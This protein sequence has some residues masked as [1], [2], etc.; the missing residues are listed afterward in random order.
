MKNNIKMSSPLIT[1][2]D[3]KAVQEVLETRYLSNG[4]KTQAFEKEL[5]SYVGSKHG[6]CVNSGTSALHLAVITAGIKD[7]DYVI[8]TPFSF[9]AS[10]NCMLFERAIPVFVDIDPITFNIDPERVD[11]AARDLIHGGKHA[12]KWLPRRM[13]GMKTKGGKLK[14]ILPVDIFGQPADYDPLR[15]TCDQ[16]DLKMIEDSCEAFGAEYKKQKAGTLGDVGVF[17]FYPNKQMTTGEG[18]ILVTDNDIWANM[19]RSLRNQGRDV[20]DG[21]LNHS[22]LGYNYRLDE[23][24]AALG[25]SQLNRI[26]DLLDKR[27]QVAAWYTNR[28]EKID[29][30]Q[31]PVIV[32]TTTKMSWFVYVVRITSD[33]G[34]DRVIEELKSM[35]IPSRQYFTPI[36]LQPFYQDRFG[37]QRDD[38]PETESAGDQCLALP[39][40]SVM[41]EDQVDIVCEAIKSILG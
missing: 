22:R 7:G 24:S 14:A 38:Y 10:A 25:L 31:T 15:K 36:H 21:W 16:Y 9:V 2:E 11:Q 3:K 20:F 4:P 23:M 13:T 6:V 35:G 37:Y 32:P 26:E 12:E 40:S 28:L 39:F 34:R 17:A 27:S 41:P 19:Y 33:I 5:A 1:E 18:G 29:G 30:I 8:T